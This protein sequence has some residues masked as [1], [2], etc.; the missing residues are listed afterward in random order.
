MGETTI[1]FVETEAKDQRELLCRWVEALC[2]K[3]R[4]IQIVADSTLDAQT[5]DQQLWTFSDTSFVSHRV[6]G[7]D[8]HQPEIDSVMIT[9]GA[10]ELSDPRDA[11]ICDGAASL[12]FMRRFGVAVHFIIVSDDL[13]KQESRNL[14]RAAQS[15]GFQLRHVRLAVNSPERSLNLGVKPK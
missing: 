12:D 10:A 7:R 6:F 15:Q 14:W 8:A 3:G 1:Y 9:I 11:L 2:E 4:K 13:L 5:L